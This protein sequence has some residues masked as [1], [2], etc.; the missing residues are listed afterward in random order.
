MRIV[1]SNPDLFISAGGLTQPDNYFRRTI[2]CK[3]CG[4]Q[5]YL[6]GRVPTPPSNKTKCPH[7]QEANTKVNKVMKFK[8]KSKMVY[9]DLTQLPVRR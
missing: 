5:Y 1:N 4:E 2:K 6:L 8:N 3:H 9:K 7:C